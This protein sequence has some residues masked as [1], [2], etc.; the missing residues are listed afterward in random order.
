MKRLI[1]GTKEEGRAG[2]T[3]GGPGG[4]GAWRRRS[5]AEEDLGGGGSQGAG[6]TALTQCI[7]IQG[8]AQSQVDGLCGRPLPACVCLEREQGSGGLAPALWLHAGHPGPSQRPI[9]PPSFR[10]ALHPWA[11]FSPLQ[12]RQGSF[13]TE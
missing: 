9:S 6:Q 8:R 10:R 1:M 13:H 12:G 7:A 11:F 5:L 4:G 3:Q 2:A